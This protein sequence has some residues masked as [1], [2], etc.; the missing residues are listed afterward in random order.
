MSVVSTDRIVSA[1]V[2][3]EQ[4]YVI[5]TDGEQ[6]DAALATIF[7][8]VLDPELSL[9]AGDGAKLVSGLRTS[10][11]LPA[12]EAWRARIDRAAVLAK[13]QLRRQQAD[14]PKGNAMD[15]ICWIVWGVFAAIAVVWSLLCLDAFGR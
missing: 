3:G 1:L 7:R 11:G 10:F 4:R 5:V 9:T 12:D 6:L 13:Q 15:V 8:W 2:R 14:P